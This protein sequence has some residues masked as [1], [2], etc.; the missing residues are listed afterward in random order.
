M[1]LPVDT[2]ASFVDSL[3][4]NLDDHGA[5]GDEL[6]ARVHLSRFHFDRVVSAVSGGRRRASAA[7]S[8]SSGPRTGW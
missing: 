6:A 1:A 3:A 4:E 7:A 5:R 8:C 2:F